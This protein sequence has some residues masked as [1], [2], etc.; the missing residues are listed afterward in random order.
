MVMV[1]QMIRSNRRAVAKVIFFC[2]MRH[3]KLQGSFSAYKKTLSGLLFCVFCVVAFSVPMFAAEE[4]SITIG[5]AT[6]ERGAAIVIPITLDSNP[7]GIAALRLSVEY[8]A[9]RLEIANASSVV[10]GN[11]LGTLSH[12]GVNEDT[13]R[14]NPFR[15]LWYGT[16]ASSDMSVGNLISI[17]FSVLDNA[18]LGDAVINVTVEYRDAFSQ[19]GIPLEVSITQGGITVREQEPPTIPNIPTPVPPTPGQP[20]PPEQLPPQTTPPPAETTQPEYVPEEDTQEEYVSEEDIPE[21]YVP[22]DDIPEENAYETANTN[23]QPPLF[24]GPPASMPP[25]IIARRLENTVDLPQSIINDSPVFVAESMEQARVFL[26]MPF[27]GY[28][29]M[30]PEALVSYRINENAELV[31]LSVYDEEQS[32]MR[33]L[34]YTNKI[35]M[36]A[37]NFMEF[38]DVPQDSWYFSAITFVAAR[39]LFIGVGDNLFVPQTNMT[40]AM[41]VT[42]LSR[43]DGITD[44]NTSHFLDVDIERWY[45]SAIA[46]A[47]EEGIIDAGILSGGASGMF[48]PNDYITR[49]EMAVIFS[50]YLAIRDFPILESNVQEFYDLNQ[51]SYWAQD[52]IQIIRSSSIVH[53]VGDNRFNPQSNATRAEVAQIFTNL[54]RAIISGSHLENFSYT[55]WR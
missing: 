11:A 35:Y 4:T 38:T 22:E 34:G 10:R 37:S 49:E 12:T 24:L 43:L 47:S 45:G 33:L 20:T 7:I 30:L 41:F 36:I 21:E 23:V 6:A 3:E 16:M 52:A 50:N 5:H 27:A 2:N 46:W 9:S 55:N 15:V 1:V 51:A 40:R 18:P 28:F 32:L 17:E 54:I 29:G 48:R 26:S 25:V 44:F 8:D 53:G 42:A 39:E 31:I 19:G 14:R 13:Y